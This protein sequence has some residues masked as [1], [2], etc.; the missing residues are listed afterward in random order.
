[1]NPLK[2]LAEQVSVAQ[3]L[4]KVARELAEIKGHVRRVAEALEGG[5]GRGASLRSY[6]TDP[7]GATA[8]A[9]FEQG[10]ADLALLEALER[11]RPEAGLEEDLTQDFAGPEWKD[12]EPEDATAI[13]ANARERRE[14]GAAEVPDEEERERWG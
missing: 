13:R 12:E 6:Y 9:L 5:G 4:L 1:M 8:G 11:R 7:E 2:A 10:D 3:A 14:G